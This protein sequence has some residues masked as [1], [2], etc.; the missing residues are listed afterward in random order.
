M[1]IIC[2]RNS[3]LLTP[4]STPEVRLGVDSAL[5]R[6]GEPLFLPDH[7]AP[8]WKA[9]IC[10]AIRICRLGSSIPARH[11]ASY[12]NAITTVCVLLPED[13]SDPVPDIFGLMDR[14]FVPGHWLDYPAEARAAGF[15]VTANITGPSGAETLRMTCSENDINADTA[16]AALSR[17]ATLKMGDMII[18]TDKACRFTPEIGMTVSAHFDFPESTDSLNFK[19]K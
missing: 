19:I 1:K 8:R 2:L 16:I 15:T 4:G 12:Y 11:A 14:A 3:S 10:P 13:V 5:V 6:E 7:L 18:F 9:A 17:Y